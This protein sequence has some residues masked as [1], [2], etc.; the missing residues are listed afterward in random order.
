MEINGKTL[1]TTPKPWSELGA[2][3]SFAGPVKYRKQF[4][5][6]SV[7]K[8]KRPYLEI[9]D[10]RDYARVTLNGKELPGRA[11]QPYRWDLSAAL[12]PGPNEIQIEVLT[13][14]TSR[15]PG[16]TPPNAPAPLAGMLGPV[17]LVAY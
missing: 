16:S 4:T 7:P 2:A 15:F 10:L 6:P 9:A 17:K 13:T 3:P 5:G 8:G 14:P 1:S 11:F 12:K